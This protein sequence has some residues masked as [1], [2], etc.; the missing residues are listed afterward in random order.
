MGAPRARKGLHRGVP[1]GCTAAIGKACRKECLPARQQ[2]AGL[3]LQGSP[4]C[5]QNQCLP[6]E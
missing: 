6:C 4:V 5:G 2:R 1:Q 3:L